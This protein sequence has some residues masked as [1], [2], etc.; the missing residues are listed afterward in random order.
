MGMAV[1]TLAALALVAGLL[2]YP[3]WQAWR[4]ARWAAQPFPAAWRRI[5]RRRVPQVARL[6]ADRQL[7]LKARMLVFL[8]EVPFIGCGGLR[9]TQEMRVTV[10]AQACLLLLGRPEPMFERLRQVLLYPAAFVVPRSRPGPAG[11]QHED[12]QTLQGESWGAAGQV[13]LSWQDV[14]DGARTPDDGRNVVIHEFAHQLD[15]AHG[16]VDAP[17]NGAPALAAGPGRAAAWARVM[18]AEF[19]ALRQRCRMGEPGLLDAYGAEDPAEFLAVASEVFF[20]QPG[21]L[22]QERP[23]LHAALV[24]VYGLDPAAW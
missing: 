4:R 9:V 20:E 10:A 16:P 6:P 8:A 11:L 24:L 19:D 5:L 17:A 12:W 22:Q 3:R 18:Q 15:Q 23:H 14:L 2:G 13:I 7:Q 1:L 21:A